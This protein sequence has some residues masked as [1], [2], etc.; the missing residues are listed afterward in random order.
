[1]QQRRLKINIV[2]GIM[3]DAAGYTG[4]KSGLRL[5]I[6]LVPGAMGSGRLVAGLKAV[7]LDMASYACGC[8]QQ[9]GQ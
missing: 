8:K 3:P 1:M 7:L 5:K 2:S 4:E 6:S 9:R